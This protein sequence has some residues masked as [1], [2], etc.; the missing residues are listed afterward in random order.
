MNAYL[1]TLSLLAVAACACALLLSI[2]ATVVSLPRQVDGYARAILAETHGTRTDTVAA[3]KTITDKADSRL[4]SIQA[5]ARRTIAAT[6]DRALTIAD[7]RL[8]DTT[9]TVAGIRADLRPVLADA[10]ETL[11]QASSTI[12]V[13]RP[14]A[15]GLIAAAKVTAGQTAQAAR[16]IDGAMPE[17]IVTWNQIGQNVKRTTDASAKASEETAATMANFRKATTPMPRWFRLTFGVA[18]QVAPI[19]AAAVGAAAAAGAFAK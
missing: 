10:D 2:R 3:L 18:A 17:F 8:K 13:I 5:D 7:S 14:Q 15:L 12:A 1:R 19:G 9:A 16:R 6:A 4:A 11:Q